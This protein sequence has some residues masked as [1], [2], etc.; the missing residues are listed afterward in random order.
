MKCNVIEHAKYNIK[1]VKVCP[2]CE[3]I[4]C[5]DCLSYDSVHWLPLPRRAKLNNQLNKK[6]GQ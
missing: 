5:P 3:E 2:N 1:E 4:N 6:S